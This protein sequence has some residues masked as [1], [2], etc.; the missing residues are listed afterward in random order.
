[1]PPGEHPRDQ[2]DVMDHPVPMPD[3]ALSGRWSPVT[4][5]GSIGSAFGSVKG[6]RH[7]FPQVRAQ[8]GCRS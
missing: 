3:Q 7:P 2:V 4:S 6:E 8:M 5:A 1:M